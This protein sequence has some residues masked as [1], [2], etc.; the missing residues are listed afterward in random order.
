MWRMLFTS[1]VITGNGIRRASCRSVWRRGTLRS[2]ISHVADRGTLDTDRDLRRIGGRTRPPTACWLNDKVTRH[3]LNARFSKLNLKLNNF[4]SPCDLGSVSHPVS[5]TN[6][7]QAIC[8][9]GSSSI[10]IVTSLVNNR[11]NIT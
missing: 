11:N 7:V 4:T 1:Q 5:K 3:M 10:H 8:M 6:Q 9:P 2:L